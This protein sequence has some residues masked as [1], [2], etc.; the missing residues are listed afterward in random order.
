MGFA[1][2]LLAG[3]SDLKQLQ[4]H[5][6]L[7]QVRKDWVSLVGLGFSL[8]S[9]V[10]GRNEIFHLPMFLSNF[11]I[12]I[13]SIVLHLREG[14]MSSRW[15]HKKQFLEIFLPNDQFFQCPNCQKPIHSKPI[16]QMTN[17]QNL[18]KCIASSKSMS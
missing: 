12:S 14:M 5:Q 16:H 11:D 17:L 1:V 18:P 4:V 13:Y 2:P 6:D 7:S 10:I 9:I 8:A 15:I 3:D